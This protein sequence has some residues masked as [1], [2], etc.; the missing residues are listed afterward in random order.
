M[1]QTEYQSLR[2]NVLEWVEKMKIGPAK[3]KMS[4]HSDSSVYTSCFALFILDLFGEVEKWDS[5]IKNIWIDRINSFQ[6]VNSGYYIPGNHYGSLNSKPVHQLTCFCLSALEILEGNPLYGLKFLDRWE[7]ENDVFDYL[8]EIGVR[9]GKP[10]SGN[11]AMFLG[12]FLTYKYEKLKDASALILI[13]TWFRFHD[14]FQNSKTGF[15][16]NNLGSRYYVG[17]QN[18]F[19]IFVI[20]NYWKRDLPEYKKIIDSVLSFQNIDNHF[21]LIPGGGGCFDYDSAD[22]LINYGIK[23]SYKNNEINIALTK[24][25]SA[26][27]SIQ[28]DDGGFPESSY[29][30]DSYNKLFSSSNLLFI[31]SSK[32]AVHSYLKFKKLFAIVKAKKKNVLTH[33]HLVPYQWSESNLW[34]TWFRILTLAIADSS[35]NGTPDSEVQR[36]KF[37][38]LIGLGYYKK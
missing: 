28:N 29:M 1:T 4:E 33:W 23:N 15:W 9:D 24:L 18:A 32:S 7:T 19:H 11:M 5:K 6:D 35:L 38:N 25:Y 21:G 16:G 3:Y 22:V 2:K 30:P 27:V 36:W 10:R 26:I 20:Y 14:Q 37:H 17:F 31:L 13:N 8:E 12:I 34:D